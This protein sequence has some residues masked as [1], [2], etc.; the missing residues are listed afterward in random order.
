[1]AEGGLSRGLLGTWSRGR[2]VLFRKRESRRF[3]SIFVISQDYK[4]EIISLNEIKPGLRPKSPLGARTLSPCSRSPSSHRSRRLPHAG[5]AL[6]C[7]RLPLIPI[8]FALF[9]VV[10]ESFSESCPQL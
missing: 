3:V 9:R 4:A 5:D 6:A 10:T 7:C 1:M 8:A 2:V